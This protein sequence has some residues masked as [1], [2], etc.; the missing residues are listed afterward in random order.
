VMEPARLAVLSRSVGLRL[1]ARP[2]LNAALLDRQME[3]TRS[4]AIN[5]AME[6][7]RGLDRRLLILFW[8][9]AERWGR[10]EQG[11]VVIPLRL[12]HET[13]SLLVGARRPS[14]T[15]ALGDLSARGELK[16]SEDGSWVLSGA[17]PAPAPTDGP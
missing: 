13:L 17:P 11:H 7:V 1:C 15:T 8:H 6:N 12:T 9:L 14:V 3:R 2:E 5:A 4:L 10:R 16:R